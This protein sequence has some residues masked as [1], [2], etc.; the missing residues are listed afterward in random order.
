M[1]AENGPGTTDTARP[2]TWQRA[3]ADWVAG[4]WRIVSLGR[5]GFQLL[6]QGVLASRH[7]LLVEALNEAEKRDHRK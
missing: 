3:G 7:R 4:D 1:A 2:L 5:Q 6:R